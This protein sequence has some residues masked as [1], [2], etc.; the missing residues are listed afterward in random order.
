MYRVLIFLKSLWWH[1]WAGFPKSSNQ[2]IL[3]RFKIC[4]DCEYLDKKQSVCLQ[5]GC[6]VNTKK[7]FLNKLAW[8]D[9]KCPINK[10]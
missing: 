2:E 1:I 8:K 3:D 9:Q 5:C 4:Q 10:W 6:N 7:I